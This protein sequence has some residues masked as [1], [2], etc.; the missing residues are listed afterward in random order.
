[1]VIVPSQCLTTAGSNLNHRFKSFLNLKH[2]VKLF[3]HF[4]C[5]NTVFF[6]YIFADLFK[7]AKEGNCEFESFL[8]KKKPTKHFLNIKKRVDRECN[9]LNKISVKIMSLASLKC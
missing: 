9:M 7:R 5:L 8:D 4:S 3:E 2:R 6:K 1:M